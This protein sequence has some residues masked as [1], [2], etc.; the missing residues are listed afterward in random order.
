MLLY[1]DVHLVLIQPVCERIVNEPQYVNLEFCSRH[2][3]GHSKKKKKTT[4]MGKVWIKQSLRGLKSDK[5]GPA[6]VNAHA[7]PALS[8]QC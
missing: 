6:R 1:S 5:A 7:L 4:K 8:G 2:D 3:L